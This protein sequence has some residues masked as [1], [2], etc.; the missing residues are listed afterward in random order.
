MQRQG[1]ET[2]SA[3]LWTA[4]I[5]LLH[6]VA[7]VFLFDPPYGI[8]NNQPIIE[9]DWG[10]HFHQLKSIQSFWQQDGML[11]GYNPF[12]MAGYP[13][14]TIQDLSIK[15]FELSA[16]ILSA[17]ALSPIQWFKIL[18]FL[19][20]ACVPWFMYFAA[21]NLFFDR[22]DIKNAAALVAALLGT[23][24]WWNSL[25]RE[26]FFYGMIGY[27]PASY[28][29]VLGVTLLYRIGKTP[30]WWSPAHLGW[31]IVALVIPSLHL[32]SI[33]IFLLPLVAL[34]LVQGNVFRR[35]LLTWSVVG[36]ALSI[37]VN[38]PWLAPAFAH[39]ADGVYSAMVDQLPL[40][41]SVDPLTFLKDYLAPDR[42][43][44][45]RPSPFEKGFRLMLLW[46]GLWGTWKLVRS[47]NRE[48]GILLAATWFVLVLLVYFGSLIPSVRSWQ[49]LRFK[50]PLDLFFV[51]AASYIVAHS[52]AQRSLGLRSF[53]LPAIAASG[54]LAFL[55]N[56][57]E[58]ETRGK[59]LL[60]TRLRPE[61]TAIVEWIGKSTPAEARVLFEESGDETGFVYDGTYL[62]SFIPQRAN[63]QLIGGP[64]NVWYDRHHF[65]EFH[66]GKLLKKDIQTLTD[67]TIRNYF[68]LYNIGAVVAFH[69]A[70]IQRLQSV[71]GL[72]TV[73]QRVGPVHLMRV[74]Q[75]LTWFLQGE[76]KVKASLN[77][78]DLSELKGKEIVLKYHWTEGLAASPPARIVPVQISDDPIPF[79]KIIEPPAAFT[80][81][82]G[83]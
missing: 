31:V 64:I 12:F 24:Y 2:R 60:R 16:L 38:L 10:L 17:L 59:M 83:K 39:R 3:V 30:S 36:A 45:F 73:D 14:N 47:E 34:L 37:L 9:Q 50:V 82:I 25:P 8:V 26:M 43:W 72:V 77:R 6:C 58:T 66:S 57:F 53:V 40:F 75:P 4:A 27:A 18:S 42:F 52:L 7:L 80:L 65:A 1:F 23:A 51:V 48:A 56:L 5:F 33:A 74:N 67:E 79:I 41:I 55:F 20:V 69:P 71:P 35:N 19:A 81:K 32:Q 54:L 28:T 44:S 70:S 68:R 13:S 21:R 22:D 29:S 78:L 63:R 49:P 11:W 15:F 76:G 61:L 62:S 46:L